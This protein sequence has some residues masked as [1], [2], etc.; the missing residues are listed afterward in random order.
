[1]LGKLRRRFILMT[2]LLVVRHT[3]A[4][5]QNGLAEL[6]R[7]NV[8]GRHAHLTAALLAHASAVGAVPAPAAE[9]TPHA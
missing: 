6:I 7:S 4:E 5:E 2:M 1:M 9:L 3:R 8:A